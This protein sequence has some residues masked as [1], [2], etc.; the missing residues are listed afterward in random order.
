MLSRRGV[1]KGLAGLVLG[2]TGFASYA[3][4]IEPRW[5]LVVTDYGVSPTGWPADLPLTIAFVSDIHAGE[6]HMSLAR[7][8]D[9]VERTNALGADL[10]LLGGDFVSSQRIVLQGYHAREWAPLLG[11][12]KAP[13]GVYAVLG[14]HDWWHGPAPRLPAD[15]GRGIRDALVAASI[16]VLE[17]D[18]VAFSH[19]GRRF[20]LAGLGDQLAHRRNG[21][22]V[23]GVDDLAGTLAQI[24]DDAPVILLAHEPDIFLDEPTP[25]VSLT[26]SGHTHGGQIRLFGYSPVVPSNYGK[27]LAYGHIVDGN[28]HLIVSGGLGTSIFPVRIGV[29]PEIVRIRLGGAAAT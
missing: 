2:A 12:L 9:I 3:F 16:P 14:N 23:G 19:R 6:P 29:P 7:I 25:R 27:R 24:T 22:V 15:G 5:R 28:R 1:L 11:R 20:W 26:L 18:V 17:N 13:L 4:A 10:V 8:A 21:L